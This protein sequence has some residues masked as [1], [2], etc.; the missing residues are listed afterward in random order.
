[1][2][3]LF[4][5]YYNAFTG[6]SVEVWWL[7]L[8]TF[9]NRSGT[10]VIPF[11]SLYLNKSLGFSLAEVGWVMTFFGIGSVI[12]SWIG[13]KL[14]DKIGPYLVMV[15]SL[16]SSGLMFFV[17]QSLTSLW[18][19]RIG[20]LVLM[21]LADAFRPAVFVAL[22]QYSKPENKIR[23]VSLVRL[24]I[25][26]GFSIGPAIGGWIIHQLGYAY[27]FWLDGITCISAGILMI[28][29]LSPKKSVILDE[30]KKME[31][32]LSP[33]KDSSYLL[34]LL[35]LMFMS[36]VFLQY[37]S[38]VPL[39]YKDIAGISED[40]IGLLMAFNGI[41]I[42]IAEMPL[43]KYLENQKFS[44][45]KMLIVGTL[46][47]GLSLFVVLF[48]VHIGIIIL[49]MA[50]MSFGEMIAFPFSN[51]IALNS[52]KKGLQGQY[53]ALYSITFS[54]GHIFG[55]NSG[56][57]IIHQFGYDLTW[58]IMIVLIFLACGILF[59]YGKRQLLEE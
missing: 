26:L 32:P 58:W 59:L 4:K 28:F 10:M 13:G 30:I 52:A 15:L 7:S 47:V 55:H 16:I 6:L 42:F 27:L 21:I 53:M 46:M 11:I 14:T 19:F 31:N 33:W 37:F 56:M 24:A 8:I 38:T 23:S 20:I 17:L 51:A 34:F 18:D 50:L 49:G 36:L 3:T 22:N 48:S 41:L 5:N 35:G 43:V 57:Q 1:M 2:N 45:V 54:V 9:I 29:L 39:F 40:Q 12:G 25:N 44:N